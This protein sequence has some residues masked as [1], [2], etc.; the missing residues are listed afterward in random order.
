MD[1]LPELVF[2]NKL[3]LYLFIFKRPLDVTVVL[4]SIQINYIHMVQLH[5]CPVSVLFTVL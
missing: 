1:F 5:V 4:A 3:Y 2:P